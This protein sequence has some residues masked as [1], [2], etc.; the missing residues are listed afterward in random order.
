MKKKILLTIGIATL[1]IVLTPKRVYEKPYYDFLEWKS[2]RDKIV[3]KENI[4]LKWEDFKSINP[5]Y[6]FDLNASVGL[7]IRYFTN[8]I[9]FESKTVFMPNESYVKNTNDTINLRISLAKFNLLE[10]YRRKMSGF[11]MNLKRNNIDTLKTLDFDN[12]N[13]RYYEMFEKE[14]EAYLDVQSEP[15]SLKNL[16]NKIKLELKKT[17]HNTVYN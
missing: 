6:E 17:N 11:I 5:G 1:I 8:P 4:K 13:L 2:L 12:M 15:K 9:S 14:W 3:W 7:S 10:I 16:E